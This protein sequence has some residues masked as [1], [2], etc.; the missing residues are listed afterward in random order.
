[1][2]YQLFDTGS[3]LSL[4]QMAVMLLLTPF[5]PAALEGSVRWWSMRGER[6]RMA[7]ERLTEQKM[8]RY[9]EIDLRKTRQG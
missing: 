2:D 9:W 5:L 3:S 6:K 4:L 7:R 1:M 8:K